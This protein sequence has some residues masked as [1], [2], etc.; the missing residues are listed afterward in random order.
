[1]EGI[2]LSKRQSPYVYGAAALKIKYDIYENNNVLKLKRKHKA[3]AKHKSKLVYIILFLFILAATI[4][5]RYT[6]ITEINYKIDN[7]R[8]ELSEIQKDNAYIKAQIEKS[9]DMDEI[10]E[11]A[12]SKLNM[13]KPYKHQILFV[14]IERQDYTLTVNRYKEI[15]IPEGNIVTLFMKNIGRVVNTFN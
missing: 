1:L 4:I 2:Q 14:D 8:T 15:K 11:Y 3:E 9:I 7:R 12:V 13:R 10:K 5:L 6:M